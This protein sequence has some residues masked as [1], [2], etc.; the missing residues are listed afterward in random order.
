MTA[1][2]GSPHLLL[3]LDRPHGRRGPEVTMK[4]GITHVGEF[5]QMPDLDWLLVMCPNP[6]DHAT[7]HHSLAM[8][9]STAED[10]VRFE[11]HVTAHAGRATF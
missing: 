11:D 6:G 2:P 5:G 4:C 1:V 10:V 3:I 7:G 9:D 8:T